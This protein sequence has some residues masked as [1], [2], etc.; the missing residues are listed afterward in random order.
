MKITENQ[1]YEMFSKSL[2]KILMEGPSQQ[3]GPDVD[4]TFN[5]E[6]VD[7]N[8]KK[9]GLVDPSQNGKAKIDGKYAAAKGGKTALGAAGMRVGTVLGAAAM[10]AMAG[11]GGATLALGNILNIA[12]LGI[13][14]GNYVS[15]INALNKV[16]K[17]EFPKNPQSAMKYARYAAAERV[18]AQ[19][20]CLNIQQN[21][22]NAM[23][24]WNLV[25]T[26]ETYDWQTLLNTINNQGGQ[27]KARFKDRGQTQQIDVDFDKNLT[28]KNAGQN[29][30]IYHG[31]LLEATD[32]D[33]TIKSVAE[34]KTDFQQDKAGGEQVLVGLGEA[35]V[36]SYGVWM[37]WT[38]YINVL[39]HKFQ[40]YGVTW[41]RVIHSNNEFGVKNTLITFANELFGT[42]IP[43]QGLDGEEEYQG[44][45][46]TKEIILRLVANNWGT[47][48]KYGRYKG[49]S[50]T[51]LQQEKTN[52]F[53]ALEPL[54]YT[55]MQ[56]NGSWVG[57]R[58]YS[59]PLGN[60]MV[61]VIR[62]NNG[63]NIQNTNLGQCPDF[64]NLSKGQGI[65]FNYAPNMVSNT[66]QDPNGK[67]IYI[68]KPNAAFSMIVFDD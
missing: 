5:Q 45:S 2:N 13:L 29:E 15:N 47:G 25:Y 51:L 65:T 59:N 34:F 23:N 38:R 10:G 67:Y 3:N 39:V 68:L 48:A 32:Y 30:S 18:N 35:Y 31:D 56:S 46:Q 42:K 26:G 52:N 63:Q 17:L 14:V 7:K 16:S 19:Q 43:L 6:Y 9:R 4:G 24:A 60:G 50:Y 11:V 1:L 58:L 12:G 27:T 55:A 41:E 40:K 8:I 33:K 62:V 66:T 57:G 53:F 28:D 49:T 21:L 61:E 20:I 54:D 22:K 37:Q 64:D 36:K 44:K